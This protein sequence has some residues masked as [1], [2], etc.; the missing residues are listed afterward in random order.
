M[1]KA[2]SLSDFSGIW[3]RSYAE[4]GYRGQLRPAM[5]ELTTLTTSVTELQVLVY[6]S[7]GE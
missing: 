4:A 1:Q 5:E 2:L 3:S 7:F 6:F